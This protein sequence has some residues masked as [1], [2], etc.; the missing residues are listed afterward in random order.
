M[1]RFEATQDEEEV[2]TRLNAFRH[3]ADCVHYCLSV[4][5]LA[6]W[7]SR[8]LE[9]FA[10]LVVDWTHDHSAADIFQILHEA[11]EAAAI[12]RYTAGA[13]SRYFDEMRRHAASWRHVV[14]LF[15]HD[16]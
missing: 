7:F 1:I 12:C 6:A 13:Q 3:F 8:H 9:R 5:R 11:I 2:Y 16:D 14:T 4:D 10:V 15:A